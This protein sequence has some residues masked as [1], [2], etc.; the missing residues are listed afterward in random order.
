[1]LIQCRHFPV[2]I[3]AFFDLLEV[4]PGEPWLDRGC[5]VVDRGWAHFIIAKPVWYC[6]Q[7]VCAV[8]FWVCKPTPVLLSLAVS[9]W[10]RLP[11]GER[12]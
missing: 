8:H 12:V 6:H 7:L 10:S 9:S 2:V 5:T 11:F 4:G 3:Y 1:M